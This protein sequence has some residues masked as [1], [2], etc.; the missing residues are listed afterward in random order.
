MKKLLFTLLILGGLGALFW[1]AFRPVPVVVDVGRVTRGPLEVTLDHEARTRVRDRYVIRAP[2]S[3][4]LRRILL[5]AGDTIK[6]GETEL[7]VI[8]PLEP[9]LLDDR[10]VARAEARVRSAEANVERAERQR[11]KAREQVRVS[12]AQYEREKELQAKQS[13]SL[14]ALD[15]AERDLRLWEG[16]LRSAEAGVKVARFELS[17]ARAA[18]VRTRPQVEDFPNGLDRK[19]VLRAPI[20]GRVFR[21]QRKSRG[22]VTAGEPLLELG[23]TSALEIV[24]D[25]LSTDAVRMQPGMAA[26]VWGW[27]GPALS[28]RVRLIEPSGFTKISA[29]GVEE[30]R[31]N[32]ILDITDSA[33]APALGD[34]FRVEVSVIV[35]H[36]AVILR[37]PE[38]ALFR[39]GDGWSVYRITP[40]GRAAS[41]PLTIGQRNGFSAELRDGLPEGSALILHPSDTVSEGV[42]VQAR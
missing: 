38:S 42:Q 24:A 12:R 36:A 10:S 7:A 30:Q 20:D 6:T 32:V 37:V 31:V 23:D 16:D 14:E 28:A 40:D 41:T 25:Y 39:Q 9:A 15:R 21:V 5:D 26:R 22:P 3:G 1:L 27:G 4:T 13:T 29:L 34:G 19:I 33:P 8:D 11:D 17:L 2:L 18:L 35:F